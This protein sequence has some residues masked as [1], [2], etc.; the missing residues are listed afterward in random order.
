MPQCPHR[1]HCS[2]GHGQYDV[3][4]YLLFQ[5]FNLLVFPSTGELPPPTA[6]GAA[7]ES[8]TDAQAV[9]VVFPRAAR[10]AVRLEKACYRTGQLCSVRGRHRAQ[11]PTAG[12]F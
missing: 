2:T 12:C 7:R 10:V 6:A 11:V 4:S 3:V 8:G 9:P 5:D 1:V